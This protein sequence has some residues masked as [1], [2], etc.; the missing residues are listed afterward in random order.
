MINRIHTCGTNRRWVMAK[1]LI[2]DRQ[3]VMACISNDRSYASTCLAYKYPVRRKVGCISMDICL[4]KSTWPKISG[5]FAESCFG[6]T[7]IQFQLFKSV[8][9]YFQIH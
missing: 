7:G 9:L 8:Y 2:V 6:R 5:F 1:G 4:S 3:D